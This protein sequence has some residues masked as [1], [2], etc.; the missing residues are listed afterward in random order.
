MELERWQQIEQ[1][2]HSALRLEESRRRAFLEDSCKDEALRREVESLL[3]QHKQSENFLESPAPELV[4]NSPVQEQ[5][6]A[7]RSNVDDLCLAGKT[8]SHY[9]VLEKLGGGGMGVVYR[10]E[11]L[12]LG[13]SVALKFLPEDLA[14]DRRM[15]EQ[16]QREA[17]AASALNHPHICT[18]HDIDE[19]DGRPFIVMELLEGQTLKHAI[20]GKPFPSDQ[21]VRLAMEIADAL[22][23]AHA[24]GIIHRDIKPANIFLTQRGHV[25][26]LDFGLAKVLPSMSGTTLTTLSLTETRPFAGTLPYMAPE[27]VGGHKADPRTD[28]YAIGVVLY[29]MATGQRPF[30]EELA[31]MLMDAIS[32]QPPQPPGALIGTIPAELERITLKCLEKDAELRYQSAKELA[33]D[34]HRLAR[35]DAS[36]TKA[37]LLSRRNW[38]V[39]AAGVSVFAVV[40]ALWFFLHSSR[41]RE[42]ALNEVPLTSYVGSEN[43]P[44]FSPDGSQIAYSWNGEKQ[45]NT[46]IYVKLIGTGPPLRLTTDPADDVWPAWSPDGQTIAFL[47]DF[48]GGKYGLF[49]IPALGGQERKLLDVFIPA[50]AQSAWL[51]GPYLAWLPD[52]KG[53]IFTNKDSPEHPSS[54][55]LLRVDT[56][57]TR[58]LTTVPPGALG[59]SAPALSP[60]GIRLVFSRMTGMG[61]GDLY[62]VALNADFSPAGEPRQITFFNWRGA[63]GAWTPRGR[64]IVFSFGQKLWRINLSRWTKTPGKPERIE[65]IW[66]RS[67]GMSPAISRQGRRLAY[68]SDNSG[69]L[70]IWRLGVPSWS[71]AEGK[72]TAANAPI[73]L[74]SS[75]ASEFAPQYSRDGK[76]IAFESSRTGNL[77]IWTCESDG[78]SCMRLSSMGGPATGTPDWSPDGERIAFYSR[79]E[80][81]A[82][83]FII[84]A[85]GGAPQR[86]TN[87]DW[88]NFFPR[89]SR[90]GRWI[91][92]ASNRSGKNQIWKMPLSGGAPVQITQNGGFACTESPDGK[93]LYYTRSEDATTSVWKIPAEGG[94]ETKVLEGVIL[95]NF[96]VTRRGLYYMTQTD[97]RTRT[98]LIQFLSFA[99]RKTLLVASIQQDVYHGFSVSTDERWILYDAP[100]NPGGSNLMVV[101]NFDLDGSGW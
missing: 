62:L 91:Y 79:P 49:I 101:E 18:I 44:T 23:A 46:D 90:D 81:K 72:S 13:R 30:R 97:P 61:P 16:L 95:F 93:Y 86:L 77:E 96:A 41:T 38:R 66:N 43:S 27:Q 32:Y 29:E 75:T 8:I 10:A 82:Q 39:T 84:N 4:T 22:D 98:K 1:L 24:K 34:L 64:A 65:F 35:P 9:R 76:K 57:E 88:E 33:V 60:D 52:S 59:D 45:D 19:H 89:W 25:K 48:R 26:V 31:L 69:P 99:D 54:L 67:G 28:I 51:P 85:E 11:D 5:A 78:T 42:P 53:I 37:P 70:N 14:H 63:G 20:A 17:R 50:R 15:V 87:D 36:V 21:V 80:G 68:V 100:T 58:R 40:G 2:Y 3:A 73:H 83:I 6:P 12:K 7:S 56:L 71:R 74:I 47:R 55:F 92:F 94:A